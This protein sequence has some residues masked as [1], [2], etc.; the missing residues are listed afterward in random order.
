MTQ[1]YIY[2]TG[3][4][5]KICNVAPRTVSKWFDSG[6]LKGYRIPGSM[7]RRIPEADLI[8]FMKQHGLPIPSTLKGQEKVTP[9]F[10]V[11]IDS[12]IFFMDGNMWCCVRP[13]F[14]NLQESIA[15]F[16]LTFKEAYD[17]FMTKDEAYR[18]VNR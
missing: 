18:K 1:D 5:S 8:S 16:G 7:D 6:R 10:D 9:S 4:V 15:G 3:E 11:P 2:T 14:V 13:G 17:D 12:Y